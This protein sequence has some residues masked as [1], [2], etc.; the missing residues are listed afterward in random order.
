[1]PHTEEVSHKLPWADEVSYS[2][3]KYLPWL[4]EDDAKETLF[5]SVHGY[6]GSFYPGTPPLSCQK[7]MS[8]PSAAYDGLKFTM[9]MAVSVCRYRS[10]QDPPRGRVCGGGEG[11]RY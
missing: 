3:L 10:D 2:R 8:P 4:N 1:M 6:S 5:I 9:L 7:A 11:Q